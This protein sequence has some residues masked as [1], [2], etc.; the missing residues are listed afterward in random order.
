MK[1]FFSHFEKLLELYNEDN[2]TKEDFFKWF[3]DQIIKYGGKLPET[4]PDI[5]IGHEA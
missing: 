5:N 4:E 3:C 2:L 1:E